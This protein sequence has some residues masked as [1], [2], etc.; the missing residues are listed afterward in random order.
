LGCVKK[1]MTMPPRPNLSSSVVYDNGT[2]ALSPDDSKELL[3]Y[4]IQLEGMCHD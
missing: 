2:L 4:I 1:Q 3:L